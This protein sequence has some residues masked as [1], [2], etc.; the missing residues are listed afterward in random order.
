ML[1]LLAA[2]VGVGCSS[3]QTPSTGQQGV[4]NDGHHGS[5][6]LSLVPVTGV[7]LN[8]VHY[9][10]AN[11]ATPA[12]TI[13]EGDLP[14]PGTA[15]TFS[16][17][18]PL[19]VGTGYSISLSASSAELNDDITCA[20][21]YGPFNVTPNSSTAFTLTLT[22]KDN[23]S[24]SIVGGVDVK[25]DACPRLVFDY[26]VAS[27]SAANIGSKIAVAT[28]AHD[29]DGKAVTYKWTTATPVTGTFAPTTG[30]TSD[31]TC[32]VQSPAAG[33]VV[34][35]TAS[36]GEC[37]K[38]LT[39]TVSCKSVTCGNGVLDPG[40]TC[41]TALP[42]SGPCP[43]DC[44]YT[45]GD[46]QAEAPAEDCDPGNTAAC[47]ATCHFRVQKCGDG[48][49]T[50]TEKCDG[51]VFPVGTPPGTICATDCLSSTG[52]VCGDGIVQAG[53]ECDGHGPTPT[54]SQD[55]KKVST[56]ACVD[57]E[58]AGDCFESVNNC[59]GPASAPFT[60]AQQALCYAVQECINSTNCLDGTGSPGACYCG[61]LSTAVCG[62]A[63][64]DLTAPGAPN[65]KCAAVIQAGMPGVTSNSVVQGNYTATGRPAGA[66]IQR[67]NCDKTANGSACLSSCGLATG[68]PAFP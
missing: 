30:A 66:A 59:L 18:V 11:S 49:I 68:G 60:A 23:T 31:F 38:T 14:T 54:C 63:P 29:L 62:A 65:G 5:V 53:E 15:S 17:G 57:C 56:Q 20:G 6:G 44:T 48:F 52:P 55:C 2:G 8:S 1:A 7:T 21:S 4:G 47:D 19:P 9:V 32:T 24:G 22:C 25:T 34:T 28:K 39:T 61:T 40:E 12:V 35:V 26:A 51:T 33:S 64:F 10:V 3:S 27:P 50:G 46:G 58:N 13:S 45:C 42:S 41:D 16:F 36:N 43:A 37:T 67:L